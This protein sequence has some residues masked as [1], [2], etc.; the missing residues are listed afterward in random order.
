LRELLFAEFADADGDVLVQHEVEERLLGAVVLGEDAVL[1][2]GDPIAS[3]NRLGG[4]GNVGQHIVEVAVFGIDEAADFG[5]LL[6]A[7]TAFGE[8]FE[9]GLTGVG[10]APELAQFGFVFEEVGDVA[11]EL[12]DELGGGD[13]FA[14][15][16]PE[17]G[18]HRV[19]DCAL[20]AVGELDDDLLGT[21][22]SG[23]FIARVVG[24]RL[25][26]VFACGF[27]GTTG[28]DAHWLLG[29]TVPFRVVEM[30]VGFHEV[31]DGEVVFAPKG[32]SAAADDLFELDDGADDPQ[33]DDVADVA[34]I[35]TGGELL[36]GG[37]DG[38]DGF[39]V[40]LEGAQ[41]LFAEFA[42]VSGDADAI[43]RIGA[44]F[45]LDF[46]GNRRTIVLSQYLSQC[47]EN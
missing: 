18:L 20:F 17:A 5:E 34:G 29:F 2:G 7:V 1:A 39:L 31:V 32:A 9:E 10:L 4:V 37:E 11:E 28:G 42:V 30:L 35:D 27:A 23:G 36:G 15:G 41:V 40:V 14:V 44:D 21:P 24:G 26:G 38:G 8:S 25:D 22:G 3:R 33:Q 43:V 6:V 16:T 13:G 19:L 47:V 45:V 12:G 46:I